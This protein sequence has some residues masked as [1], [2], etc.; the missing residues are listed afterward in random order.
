MNDAPVEAVEN[1]VPEWNPLATLE[2]TR[3]PLKVSGGRAAILCRRWSGADRLAYEDA[4]TERMMTKDTAGEE[5]VK[6][7]TLRLF[8]ISITVRGAEGFPERDGRPMFTGSRADVEA[9]LLALDPDTYDEIR[10]IA[11]DVQPLPS[12]KDTTGEDDDTAGDDPFPTPS[13]PAESVVGE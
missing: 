10:A 6:I 12:A 7:G 2:T 5:T 1:D 3:H 9:D 13:T 11:L 4:L 8:A